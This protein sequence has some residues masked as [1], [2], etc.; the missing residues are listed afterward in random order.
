MTLAEQALVGRD[1]DTV[2]TPHPVYCYKC[3]LIMA[4]DV[5]AHRYDAATY[6]HETCPTTPHKTFAP[7]RYGGTS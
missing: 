7:H 6:T 3:N 2:L 4:V 1:F 5:L